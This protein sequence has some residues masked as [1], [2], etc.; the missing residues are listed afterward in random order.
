MPNS[1]VIPLIRLA[2]VEDA[3]GV[4][5]LLWAVKDDI[6]LTNDKFKDDEGRVWVREECRKGN[7]WIAMR[8]RQRVGAMI[9]DGKE[10]RYVAALPKKQVWERRLLNTPSRN[11]E[12]ASGL[13]SSRITCP[14]SGSWRR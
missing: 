11:M 8:N 5:S 1:G 7:V 3:D 4:H 10:I 12:P 6:P 14:L 2:T 13:A 9:M